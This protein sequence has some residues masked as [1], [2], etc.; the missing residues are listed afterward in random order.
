MRSTGSTR[1]NYPVLL[2][3]VALHVA[4]LAWAMQPQRPHEAA[5]QRRAAATTATPPSAAAAEP[6]KPQQSE[7]DEESVSEL[8]VDDPRRAFT[9]QQWRR[10]HATAAQTQDQHR[11]GALAD[12]SAAA[13]TP[14]ELIQALARGEAAAATAA[15]ELHEDC[16]ALAALP[17]RTDAVLLQGLD[18]AAQALARASLEARLQRLA[19]RRARCAAWR[20]ARAELDMARRAYA[21]RA[22]ADRFEV[23]RTPLQ[24][25]PETPGLLQRLRE[26]LQALWQSQS[27]RRVG[28]ALALQLLADEGEAQNA[29]GLRLLLELAERND[30]DVEFVAAVLAQGYGRLPPQPA[31]AAS[32]QR[33]A[34]E[35]GADAAIDA[36]LAQAEVQTT[37]ALA[38]SWHAW[39]IW[40]N[41]HGCYVDS[42]SADDG[43]LI[44]DLGALRTLDA[45]LD[46]AA[47]Q[48]AAEAYR[49]RIAR[50]GARAREA[51][52]CDVDRA[53]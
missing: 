2:G 39:R 38:W 6:T 19:Q 43:L 8:A 32:W 33:R 41:A 35:L 51:R 31:L 34:A 15:A 3:V 36:Q 14:A 48:A 10:N 17:E 37:P 53:D 50:Y 16:T 9:P 1:I 25:D 30:A 12:K 46:A 29:I 47:R 23:L 40:L 22:D 18:A 45:R 21:A 27:Q 4:L 11:Y 52:G 26:E 7:T 20:A 49:E 24:L 13:P 42:T 28:R 5:T 44:T